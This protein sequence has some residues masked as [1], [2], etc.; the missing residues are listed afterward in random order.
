M[1]TVV[2]SST[3]A[4]ILG[5][6][7]LKDHLR[8][9]VSDDDALIRGYLSAAQEMIESDTRHYLSSR[10]V[11]ITLDDWPAVDTIKLGYPV[12]A[13]ASVKYTDSDGDVSTLSSANYVVDLNSMPARLTL[14]SGQSWPGDTLQVTGGIVIT[15]TVGY[16][17]PSEIPFM[18]KAAAQLLV[19]QWYENREGAQPTFMKSIPQG[20]DKMLWGLRVDL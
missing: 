11:T 16:E 10:V 15:A 1:I 6:A 14:K 4:L 13:V 5:L 2:N 3:P 17:T 9:D 12:T 20:I 8:V 18:A 19:G 7:E